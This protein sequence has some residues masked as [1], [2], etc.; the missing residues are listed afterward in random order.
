MNL[1]AENQHFI[2]EQKEKS[3]LNF[4]IFTCSVSNVILRLLVS[5]YE[6]VYFNRYW[7]SECM[8]AR[9]DKLNHLQH[10]RKQRVNLVQRS[11]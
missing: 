11:S 6:T 4:R 1:S 2:R 5:L 3:V 8:A 9:L 7:R 10:D